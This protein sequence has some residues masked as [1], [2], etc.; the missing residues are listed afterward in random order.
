MSD[1]TVDAI[2][3]VP[4]IVDGGETICVTFTDDVD[5]FGAPADRPADHAPQQVF[6]IDHKSPSS[7]VVAMP[8][9]IEGVRKHPVAISLHQTV[10]FNRDKHTVNVN[11]SKYCGKDPAILP[12][13]VAPS[14][15]GNYVWSLPEAVSPQ[16]GRNLL[17][18]WES[19]SLGEYV[20]NFR[21]DGIDKD[22]TNAVVQRL[23]VAGALPG[24]TACAFVH[25]HSASVDEDA[26]HRLLRCLAEA[27]LVNCISHTSTHS[28]WQL[29][30]AAVEQIQFTIALSQPHCFFR[31]TAWPSAGSTYDMGTHAFAGRRRL[32]A[33]DIAKAWPT[34]REALHSC[35]AKQN[36]V[37]QRWCLRGAA[38]L[39][40]D[41][42][43][44]RHSFGV[45][46]GIKHSA[47]QDVEVLRAA[48]QR[49]GS[50][51]GEGGGS[52]H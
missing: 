12:P 17:V 46:Q 10:R 43:A 52:G 16:M 40:A 50:G 3:V 48:S 27:G 26:T 15:L 14:T 8:S 25:V 2:S 18:V 47:W 22:A 33:Q 11:G 39:F 35:G 13:G 44:S 5:C 19:A 45:Q 51:K 36:L 28:T 6:R 30:V 21:L 37:E 29:T 32:G 49:E 23:V 1:T 31:S 38:Q 42:A 41:D 34:P 7:Q 20:P 24:D 4:A 9:H